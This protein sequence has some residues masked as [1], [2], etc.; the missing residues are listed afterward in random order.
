MK[1][2]INVNVELVERDMEIFKGIAETRVMTIDQI[3]RLFFNG[4]KNYAYVRLRQLKQAGYLIAKPYVRRITGQK[5]GTC[6]YLTQA[7]Y[8][9]I[10]EPHYNPSLLIEPRKHDYLIALSELYVQLKPIGWQWKD[11]RKV[12]AEN[13]L[14][15][16]DRIAGTLTRI[17]PASYNGRDEYALYLVS[18]NPQQEIIELIQAEL[19][20]NQ[21]HFNSAIILHQGNQ[22]PLIYRKED[23]TLAKWTGHC[24]MYQLHIM[25]YDEGVKLLK[26]MVDP[27]YILKDPFKRSW[28]AI[29]AEYIGTEIELFSSHIVKYRGKHCYLV[30]L[31]TNNQTTIYHL[32]GFSRD[33]AKKKDRRV[34][35]LV[36][37]GEEMYWRQQFNEEH[38]PHFAFFPVTGIE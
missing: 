11:S 16:N 35:I 21:Q 2:A 10:G 28:E 27:N 23:G 36:P 6:Y 29:G 25:Q 20:R 5:I 30:E 4:N 34:I 31:V 14:N 37:P 1:A 13:N 19:I 32:H 18:K 12:K 24:D 38:Y 33:D 17:N 15:R 22:R 8:N 9:A 26:Y 7:G 3:S